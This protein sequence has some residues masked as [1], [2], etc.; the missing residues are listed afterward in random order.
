MVKQLYWKWQFFNPLWNHSNEWYTNCSTYSHT[1]TWHGAISVTWLVLW[2]RDEL[3]DILCVSVRDTFCS[4]G[5]MEL[6]SKGIGTTTAALKTKGV[7]LSCVRTCCVIA[8]ERPRIHLTSS[9]SKLFSNLGLSSRA[10]STSFGCRVN[11][12]I[13]LQVSRQWIKSST[14]PLKFHRFGVK[15]GQIQWDKI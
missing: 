14:D 8:E 12:G 4:Y 6:C 5:V 2:M 13:C 10:V 9:F 3:M 1:N 11:V 15:F 7:N